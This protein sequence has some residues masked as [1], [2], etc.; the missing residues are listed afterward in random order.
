[1]RT[2]AEMVEQG[3]SLVD[4]E[5]EFRRAYVLAAL[6]ACRHNQCKAAAVM[7]VHRNTLQ[8]YLEGLAIDVAALKKQPELRRIALMPAEKEAI[9]AALR[10]GE[11]RKPLAQQYGVSYS[12]ICHIGRGVGATMDGV[13]MARVEQ[14]A[15]RH[16]QRV[17]FVESIT[18]KTPEMPIR[19]VLI[20]G[21]WVADPRRVARKVA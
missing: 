14:F 16:G 20:A 21:R 13:K 6:E 8:R 3:V 11:S 5:R 18:P 10:D 12:Y 17:E 2:I 1:M 9:R 7:G 4:A 19:K 15:F